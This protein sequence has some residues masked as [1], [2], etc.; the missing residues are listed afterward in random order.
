MNRALI[1]LLLVACSVFHLK[2]VLSAEFYSVGQF[3][4]G[5]FGT[6]VAAISSS[7]SFGPLVLGD[8]LRYPFASAFS[9]DAFVWNQ[10][11]GLMSLVQDVVPS[12]LPGLPH[13]VIT[14]SGISN[15]GNVVA[16]NSLLFDATGVSMRAAIWDVDSGLSS[17][18]N[19][20]EGIGSYATKG[21]SMDG[22]IVVGYS[23]TIAGREAVVWTAGE[24]PFS[25]G[26][27]SGGVTSSEARSASYD[28]SVIVGWASSENGGEAFRWTRERGMVGLGDLPGGAFGTQA[29]DVSADGTVVVGSGFS[30]ASGR[31]VEAFR[32]T[33]ENG[34]E[35]LGFLS[36]SE[37]RSTA[38][39]VSGNGKVIVG[40][41]G[42]DE[43]ERPFVWTSGTGIMD[44]EAILVSQGL[45]SEIAGWSLISAEDITYDGSVI[46]GN[47]V[48]PNGV[49]EGWIAQIDLSAIPEPTTVVLLAVACCCMLLGRLR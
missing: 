21:I 6:T 38:N 28:G 17:L 25:L 24:E 27:L 45:Y 12:D 33:Q 13:E 29:K 18:H 22:R 14:A 4:E 48:N 1:F 42:A 30:E 34:F 41:S 32:W 10:S 37:F 36:Q 43:N 35:I 19:L 16:L 11:E 3:P 23:H 7:S 2:L 20:A 44:L 39:A 31:S 46:I 40:S 9:G 15:F 49:R 5:D 47:G 8:G 26:D